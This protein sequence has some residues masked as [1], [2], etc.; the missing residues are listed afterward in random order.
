M[1]ETSSKPITLPEKLIV[2]LRAGG[3]FFAIA[4]IVCVGILS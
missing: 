4:N 2:T 1:S 3:P